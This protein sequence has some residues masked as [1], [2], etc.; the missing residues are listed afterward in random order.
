MALIKCRE[1][2]AEISDFAERCVK[3]GCPTKTPKTELVIKATNDLIG[4]FSYYAI[5]DDKNNLVAKLKAT[6]SF[7]VEL[8]DSDTTYYVRYKELGLYSP[9]PIPCKAYTTNKYTVGVNARVDGKVVVSK[10][11]V[12][13]SRD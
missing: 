9:K 12:F 6:E 13:D 11:D 2:G 5:Y 4:L 7:S 8:P 1:C 3:C 10:V